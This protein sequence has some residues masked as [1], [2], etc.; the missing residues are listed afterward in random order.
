MT[1]AKDEASRRAIIVAVDGSAT[2][3]Q[4]VRWAVA[5]AELRRCG[6]RIL[7]SSASAPRTGLSAMEIVGGREWLYWNGARVLSEAAAMGRHVASVETTTELVGE[8]VIETLVRRSAAVPM[9]VVGS[10]GR[11]AVGWALLGS[12]SSAVTRHARCPVA[13]VHR[14]SVVGVGA[15]RRPVVVGVD[16]DCLAVGWAF[17][18]AALRGVG[19]EAVRSCSDEVDGFVLDG[20][21]QQ[22]HAERTRTLRR[23]LEPWHR[24]YPDVPL[25]MEVV[26]GGP[27]HVLP[28]RADSA[29]LVVIGR[30]AWSGPMASQIRSTRAAL[31]HRTQCPTLVVPE[32]T[33]AR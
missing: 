13:V 5:E 1:G 22:V 27:A 19:L 17:E 24:K 4:A 30:H 33:D 7:L 31:L 10:H 32:H 16:P 12:V 8:P 3:L 18:E 9:I 21:L 23:Q 26:F 2:A 14:E 6:V 25:E 15:D 29:Q 28:D 11:G 20:E